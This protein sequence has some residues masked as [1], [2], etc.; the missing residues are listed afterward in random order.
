MLQ[1][2]EREHG[3]I[4]EYVLELRDMEVVHKISMT[5]RSYSCTRD[6]STLR[7]GWK[8]IVGVTVHDKMANLTE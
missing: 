1:A 6:Y 8:V 7:I 5:H 3:T 2:V 4:K